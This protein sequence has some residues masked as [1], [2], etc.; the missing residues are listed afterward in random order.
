MA[1]PEAIMGG[2]MG[3]IKINQGGNLSAELVTEILLKGE[4]DCRGVV[5]AAGDG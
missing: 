3:S 5:R 1:R 4:L 2:I